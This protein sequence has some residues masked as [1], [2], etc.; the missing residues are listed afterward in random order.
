MEILFYLW[1]S[2]EDLCISFP[3]I[4]FFFPE[5]KQKTLEEIDELFGQRILERT[6]DEAGRTEKE[7][8]G[9]SATN[10]ENAVIH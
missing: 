10:V 6:P 5:T 4:F 2:D 1:P 7:E 9:V 3:V 8:A